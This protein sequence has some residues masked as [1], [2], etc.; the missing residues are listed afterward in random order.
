MNYI[1][2]KLIFFK[3]ANIKKNLTISVLARMQNN[4]AG[5]R[6]NGYNHPGIQ[7]AP[8]TKVKNVYRSHYPTIFSKVYTLE[9]LFLHLFKAALFLYWKQFY[10]PMTGQRLRSTQS[11]TEHR[12][13]K[14]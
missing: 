4:N 10:L 3:L 6:V 12:T 11:E 9:K 2:I 1:S 7:F 5:R 8:F 14:E 13:E